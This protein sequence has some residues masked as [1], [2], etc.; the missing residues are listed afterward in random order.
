M[1][2]YEFTQRIIVYVLSTFGFL[3][4]TS[5]QL[6][7]SVHIGRP[8]TFEHFIHCIER[9]PIGSLQTKLMKFTSKESASY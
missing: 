3:L 6:S 5:K 7:V 8:Q 1:W 4:N 2:V 9:Q